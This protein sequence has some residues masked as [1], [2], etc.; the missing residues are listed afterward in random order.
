MKRALITGASGGVGKEL[1]YLLAEKGLSLF[2]TG[3]N[4]ASLKELQNT[5]ST[6][7]KVEYLVCDLSKPDGCAALAR[8]IENDAFDLVVN[9]AGF[10]LYGEVIALDLDEQL[11]M[12]EVNVK[13]LLH[14]S[15]VAARTMSKAAVPGVIMNISSIA[16][17]WSTPNMA[18]YGATKAFVTSFSEGLD[19]ELAPKG[20]RVL[21]SCPGMISSGFSKRASRNS[22]LPRL[23]FSMTPRKAAE[24]I[25]WQ[26][27]TKKPR[28]IFD[29]QSKWAMRIT[30]LFPR[31]L[32]KQLV[33]KSIEKRLQR[34]V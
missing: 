21:T 17:F 12:V 29:A 31:F 15:V 3:R 14:L 1:S 23:K 34:E 4:E 28:H 6:K 11:A 22:A 5:L 16:G 24:E 8:V 7:T 18:V 10:G 25:L 30:K 33:Y 26:I 27:V 13:T 32:Q 19:F 9:N 20:I 2:L